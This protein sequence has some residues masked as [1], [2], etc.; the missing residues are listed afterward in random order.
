MRVDST[1][2]HWR[3][4]QA[5][6]VKEFKR[7]IGS[8]N[9]SYLQRQNEVLNKIRQT[10]RNV[11]IS[12][13]RAFSSGVIENQIYSQAMSKNSSKYETDLEEVVQHCVWYLYD[14][15]CINQPN[16]DILHFFINGMSVDKEAGYDKSV[17]QIRRILLHRMWKL[18]FCK[19]NTVVILQDDPE[20]E[21]HFIFQLKTSSVTQFKKNWSMS[22]QNS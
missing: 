5:F 17:L 14:P 9:E 10:P 20:K 8:C 19:Y 2:N 12:H 11:G 22:T 7:E 13:W 3:I 21:F 1:D 6:Y 16:V 4:F 18:V 15:I